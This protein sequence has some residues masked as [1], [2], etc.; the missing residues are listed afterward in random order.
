LR[1]AQ[2]R[3]EVAPASTCS[4]GSAWAAT[5]SSGWRSSPGSS[6]PPTAPAATPPQPPHPVA[7]E[8][9]TRTSSGLNPPDEST[10][11]MAVPHEHTESRM[12]WR[13]HVRFGM[14]AA[15]TDRSRDRHRADAPLERAPSWSST[16]SSGRPGAAPAMA[17]PTCPG[18]CATTTPD[19]TTR[20]LP[21]PSASPP[22]PGPGTVGDAPG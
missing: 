5:R 12:R 7:C 15:G 14:R 3:C 4:T 19:R 8:T 9:L 21:S 11:V 22:A 17:S 2:G 6:G 13:S 10:E 18:W 20:R 16:P 1:Q